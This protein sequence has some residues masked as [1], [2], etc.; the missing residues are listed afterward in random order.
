MRSKMHL[1]KGA[2]ARIFET[3]ISVLITIKPVIIRLPLKYSDPLTLNL[4]RRKHFP[5]FVNSRAK[6]SHKLIVSTIVNYKSLLIRA[7]Y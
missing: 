7:L 5:V 1:E 6:I 3:V 2:F 4:T